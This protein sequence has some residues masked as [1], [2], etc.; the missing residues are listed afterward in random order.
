MFQNLFTILNHIFE[1]NLETFSEIILNNSIISE[2]SYKKI[3]LFW[4]PL[5]GTWL[6]MALE[7][8]Y[9]AAIIA[10]MG[11]PKFNLA[12][13]GVAYS[14]AL[15]A[16]SPIIMI[17][18]AATALVEDKFTFLK[19]RNFT[20][21][22]IILITLILLLILIPPVFYYITIDLI[23][24]PINVANITHKALIILL[25]WPAAIGYRR[26][27]QGVLIKYNFTRWVAYGTFIRLITM[28]LAAILLFLYTKI[29]GALVGAFALS[30]AVI[31]EA[32]ASRIMSGRAIK[33]INSQKESSKNNYLTYSEIAKFYYPLAL[34][35]LISLGVHPI[36]TFFLGQGRM[37][38]E[39]LAVLPVI[40]GLVFIFRSI[41]LSFQEVGIALM[42]KNFANYRYLKNFTL[43]FGVSVALILL[44]VAFTPA[45]YFWFNTV[46][47]LSSVLSDFAITPLQ[48]MAI[49][50]G[51]TF[52]ISFQRAVLVY[53]R[54]TK[55]ITMATVI[56]VSGILIVLF[57]SIKVFDIVGVIAAASAFIIGRIAANIFLTFPFN[58]VR[59][60]VQPEK[61]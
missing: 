10:R 34:T 31:A 51:L 9:L 45:A 1:T 2:M 39:S 15:V 12:A 28:S 8:P 49:V 24:L 38:L 21:F 25:P 18:S 42:G 6:M 46:S 32:I 3:F 14:F 22:A 44:T 52:L 30:S 56:E 5:A 16:E 7:G 61:N 11:D 36:V 55:P 37:S 29:E 19:L 58:K 41:G 26:F 48:I 17:M 57:V 59:K 50:P 13:Y 43:Y 60:I 20:F 4:L 35:S 40:N 33:I 23:N 47:G 27:Y 53:A 54:N